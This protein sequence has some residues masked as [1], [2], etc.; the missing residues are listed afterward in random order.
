MPYYLLLHLKTIEIHNFLGTP[1]EVKLV[2][3]LL[4]HAKVLVL[5]TIYWY[6]LMMDSESQTTI[7]KTK[8]DIS[9]S[10]RG[11]NT[12]QLIFHHLMY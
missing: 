8:V 1:D 5:M 11:S 9:K 2:K 6:D 10:P 4:R 7:V 3:Y 12:C